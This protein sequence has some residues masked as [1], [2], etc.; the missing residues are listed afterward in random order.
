MEF[1]FLV[2]KSKSHWLIIYYYNN[3]ITS[4]ARLRSYCMRFRCVNKVSDFPHN[5]LKVF[6]FRWSYSR[7]F[8]REARTVAPVNQ[9]S[10]RASGNYLHAKLPRKNNRTHLVPQRR[11]MVFSST[12][13]P[14]AAV[15]EEIPAETITRESL[16]CD[17]RSSKGEQGRRNVCSGCH[18]KKR[19]HLKRRG[20]KKKQEI[21]RY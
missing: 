6:Q 1:Y 21:T 20:L 19:I 4:H 17:V 10:V 11:V 5:Q 9:T 13:R 18:I 12:L 14:G 15:L 2:Q 16:Q 3:Y 7:L 8:L